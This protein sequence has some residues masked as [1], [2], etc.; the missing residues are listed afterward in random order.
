MA[1][2]WDKRRLRFFVDGQAQRE[3]DEVLDAKSGAGGA[4]GRL[5]SGVGFCGLVDEVRIS[6]VTRYAENFVPR[7]RFEPDEHTLALYHCDEGQGDVLIDSSRNEHHG[8]IHGAKWVRRDETAAAPSQPN[9]ALQF[10][11]QARVELPLPEVDVAQPLTIEAW[12]QAAEAQLPSSTC[13]IVVTGS[14]SLKLAASGQW[15][16]G[17]G[18]RGD[19]EISRVGYRVFSADERAETGRW[20]HVALTW[21][22]QRMQLYVD[23]QRQRFTDVVQDALGGEGGSIGRRDP[24]IGFCGRIDEVRIS[25]NVRYPE[26]FTPQDRFDSDEHTIALYHF[27][28]GQGDQLVD[29]SHNKYHG[30]IVGAQWVTVEAQPITP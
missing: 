26:N 29:S 24:G 27:D 4:I 18:A 16:A 3:S 15:Q 1:I 22:K 21:E 6:K 9:S 10:D 12:A 28:E 17:I 20:A 30:K 13:Y 8:Q 7:D 19:F 11:G 14:H 23:G 5:T 2:T 25:T